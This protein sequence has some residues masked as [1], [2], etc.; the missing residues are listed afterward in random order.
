MMTSANKAKNFL[1]RD[2]RINTSYRLSFAMS[3]AGIFISV[4]MFFF[5]SQL[6][7]G[8]V[9]PYLKEY[10]G[11]YFSFVLIG[12]AFSSFVNTGMS[13]FSTSISQAQSQGTLE[14]MLVTPTRLSAI[15]LF[16]S[17]WNYAFNFFNVLVY[18]VFGSLFF[19]LSLSKANIPATLLVLF[20]ATLM[21]SGIGIISA[22]FIMVF[23]RGNPIDRLHQ[24][25]SSVLSGMFFPVTVLPLW[26]Q[27]FAYVVPIF[28]A[29][30]AMRLAVLKGYSIS[31][32][33]GE[34]LVLLGLTTVILPLSI[35]SFKYAVRE[36]KKDGTLVTY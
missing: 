16:S 32:R 33:S 22:S 34:L 31:A 17:L 11:D 35:W 21:F 15:I 29:L 27:P 12:L 1:I 36:A 14:A 8:A 25:A 30:H 4:T 24:L 23:K 3:F 13:T 7:G 26:L 10:G 19:G 9:S 28:Y 5:I 18:L 20:L 2:W 6:F